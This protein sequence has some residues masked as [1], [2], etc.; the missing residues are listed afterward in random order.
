MSSAA[1]ALMRA[2]ANSEDGPEYSARAVERVYSRNGYRVRPWDP[3][4]G[5]MRERLQAALS[6]VPRP[7]RR[8]Q[9]VCPAQVPR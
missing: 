5:T 6:G 9:R 7:R 4:A 2:E 8:G 1:E 3:T